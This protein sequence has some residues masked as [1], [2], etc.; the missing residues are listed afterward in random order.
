MEELDGKLD[1]L[2]KDAGGEVLLPME[3]L[4]SKLELLVK[5]AGGEVL[6]PMEELDEKPEVLFPMD[7][8][9]EDKEAEALIHLVSLP[10]KCSWK[11]PA[12]MKLS[13]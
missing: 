8:G 12:H 4:D 6:L 10:S 5:G 9:S 1:L 3:E 7:D 11:I 2:V 13:R